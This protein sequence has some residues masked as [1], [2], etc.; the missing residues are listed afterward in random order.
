MSNKH[1]N[2]QLNTKY[3][4][5]IVLF[6][7]ALFAMQVYATVDFK[8]CYDFGCKNSTHVTL[9]DDEWLAVKK[10]FSADN[11]ADERI[12]IM[13]AIA[14]MEHLAGLHSPTFRDVARNLPFFE[15]EDNADL[16]PGQMD[17]IDESINTT[18]Y[19]ALFAQHGLLTF[20]HVIE[21]AYRRSIVT[22]HWAAQL[23]ETATGRR[24]VLDSWFS[25]NGQMPVLVSSERWH[26]LSF[27]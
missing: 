13:L 3:Y 9:S 19:L 7:G 20:H 24:F 22:Q 8:V 26:D 5:F 12:E 14:Q 21:R 17:C 11:P 6:T 4:Q 15:P 16:F 27:F 1:I 25:D 2:F 18:S 23:E 10:L